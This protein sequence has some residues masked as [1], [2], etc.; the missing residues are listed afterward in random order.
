[1]ATLTH[2]KNLC[3]YILLSI[4]VYFKHQRGNKG[5]CPSFR[6]CMWKKAKKSSTFRWAWAKGWHLI[7]QDLDAWRKI[8]L[9]SNSELEY[10][11]KTRYGSE[12]FFRS[13]HWRRLWEF[14]TTSYE[15]TKQYSKKY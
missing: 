3:T 7:A 2:T 5:T 11:L 12:L 1:M 8:F 14:A 9:G 4:H 10:F 13:Q 6:S 15:H